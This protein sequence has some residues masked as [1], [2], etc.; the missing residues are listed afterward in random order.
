VLPTA[1]LFFNG[2][3]PAYINTKAED[4][5]SRVV[6]GKIEIELA[7]SHI[8]EVD[9]GANQALPSLQR[10]RQDLTQRRN[11]HASAMDQDSF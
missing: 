2:P 8:V 4:I 6:P 10:S 1:F 3:A 5:R 7:A 11:D 9:I